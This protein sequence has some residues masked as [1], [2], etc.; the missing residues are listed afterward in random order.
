MRPATAAPSPANAATP[1]RIKI[2]NLTFDVGAHSAEQR[3]EHQREYHPNDDAD[4]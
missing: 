2:S 4:Q 3:S 1:V